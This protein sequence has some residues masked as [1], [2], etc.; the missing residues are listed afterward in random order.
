MNINFQKYQGTGND[1]IMIDQR[2]SQ[3]IEHHQTSQIALWCDRR[4]GIGADGLILLEK[5]DIAD[6]KMVYFNADG[7]LGSMCGNGGRC[8]IAFA[9][10]LNIFETDTTFEAADGL[11]AGKVN[12]DG[13]VSI[14]MTDVHQISGRDENAYELNTGSP[15]YIIFCDQI[16]HDI[17]TAGATIRYNDH[18]KKD[19]INV[20]FLKI[21]GLNQLSVATYERGVED[22]T[23]SCGT[24]VT[25]AAI[26]YASVTGLNHKQT[27][28]VSTK[29]GQLDV[30]F[31]AHTAQQF[32]DVWLRGPAQKVY[33]GSI[34]T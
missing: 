29:G 3:A 9:K 28:G 31:D 4:F 11:H 14:Q 10:S 5:S 22:E 2:E 34:S 15:H 7:R 27:I 1:F 8:I 13:T 20:N 16:P 23:F 6:F 30:S 26:C 18:Y 25:A 32:T 19:G 21:N 33:D 12:H 24:G 17:K